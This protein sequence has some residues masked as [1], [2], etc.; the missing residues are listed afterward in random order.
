[1]SYTSGVLQLLDEV[2]VVESAM[3]KSH[4]L[5]YYGDFICMIFDKAD[6]LIIKVSPGRVNALIEAGDGL[7]FNYTGKRFKEWVMIP[8]EFE[9]EYPAY[10]REALEYARNK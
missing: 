2:G 3:M 6:A 5:R 8:M 7:E 9:D 1:M 4:C 10:M